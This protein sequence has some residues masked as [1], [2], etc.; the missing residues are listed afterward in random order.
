MR[1]QETRAGGRYLMRERESA[2]V[3]TPDPADQV[4]TVQASPRPATAPL[5]EYLSPDSLLVMHEIFVF[6]GWL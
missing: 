5:V 3:C 4:V 1:A 6:H 2:D